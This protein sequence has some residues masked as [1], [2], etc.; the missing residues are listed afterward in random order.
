M[1]C[2][3]IRYVARAESIFTSIRTFKSFSSHTQTGTETHIL[4]YRDWPI[5]QSYICVSL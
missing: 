2:I 1:R 5:W 3:V 4:E